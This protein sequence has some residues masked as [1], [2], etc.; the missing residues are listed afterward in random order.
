M[1]DK[2]KL[3]KEK[4]EQEFAD[5]ISPLIKKLETER[6]DLEYKRSKGITLEKNEYVGGRLGD[7]EKEISQLKTTKS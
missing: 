2:N 1:K 4:Q 6:L 5:K 7:I 3:E